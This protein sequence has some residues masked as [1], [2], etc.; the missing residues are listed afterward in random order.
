MTHESTSS[1]LSTSSEGEPY[2]ELRE[3]GVIFVLD[4]TNSDKF[5]EELIA[6]FPLIKQGSHRKVRPSILLLLRMYL[7]LR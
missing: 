6:Y 3:S 7:L 2:I 5:W 1:T 4:V